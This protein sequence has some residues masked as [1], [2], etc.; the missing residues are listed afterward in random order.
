MYE[1]ISSSS[2]FPSLEIICNAHEAEQEE[3]ASNSQRNAKYSESEMRCDKLLLAADATMQV[4]DT[5]EW[6]TRLYSI[7][8]IIMRMYAIN[9]ITVQSYSDD[10]LYF[11]RKVGDRFFHSLIRKCDHLY[12]VLQY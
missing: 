8:M 3:P 5:A 2:F 10:V 4:Y 11:F 12:D 9:C 7:L 1:K 6:F